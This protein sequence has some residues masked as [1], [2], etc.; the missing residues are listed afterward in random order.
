MMGVP[1]ATDAVPV[2]KATNC[3]LIAT[4][5]EVRPRRAAMPCIRC[6]DCATACPASLLPQQLYWH[7]RTDQLEKAEEL[8]LFDCIECGLCDTVCPSQIPLTEY[9]RYAKTETWARERQRQH[10]D[11]ARQRFEA[12]KTRIESGKEERR[13]RLAA[14]TR[15]REKGSAAEAARKAVIADVMERVRGEKGT[16][17]S[18]KDDG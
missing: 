2:V 18:G 8:F 11:I 13:R 1:L 17:G 6:G 15:M 5:E 14:K 9:F 7:A 12:R 10:S 16:V 4:A 3:L